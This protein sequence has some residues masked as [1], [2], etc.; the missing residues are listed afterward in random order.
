MTQIKLLAGDMEKQTNMVIGVRNSLGFSASIYAQNHYPKY[1]F[2]NY[3]H[4]ASHFGVHT[5]YQPI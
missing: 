3:L 1:T 5:R 4:K 2:R